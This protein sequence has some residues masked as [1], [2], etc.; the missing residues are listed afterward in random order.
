MTLIYSMAIGL[1]SAGTAMVARRI[2]E[3]QEDA[4][5]AAFQVILLGVTI[6]ISLGVLG[7]IYAEDILRLIGAF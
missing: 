6:A 1:A 2:G 5:I 3:N 7:F 4:N